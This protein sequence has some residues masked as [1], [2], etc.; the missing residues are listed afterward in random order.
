MKTRKIRAVDVD[1]EPRTEVMSSSLL[2]TNMNAVLLL[3]MIIC[4]YALLY[5]VNQTVENES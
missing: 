2:S 1:A 4:V 3:S 5:K